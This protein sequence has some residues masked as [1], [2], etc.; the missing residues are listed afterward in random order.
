[1]AA[2]RYG[3]V[4]EMTILLARHGETDWNRENRFQGHA[5]VPL[6]DRGRE[7]A[8]ALADDLASEGITAVY[9]S[10]LSRAFETA[11]IAADRLGLPVRTD[12]RLMEVDVG[13]WSGLTRD[14]I[15]GRWPQAF[16]NWKAGVAGWDGESYD[17]LGVRTLAALLEIAARHPGE[18]V[19]AVAH[20][21]AVRVTLAHAEELDVPSHRRA[22]PAPTHNCAVHRLVARDGTLR[23]AG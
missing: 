23:R 22:F 6:N 9:S 12:P 20:G 8:R 5:D 16:E 7:Q 17:D 10:T 1:M 3:L 13:S 19:L 4:M 21:G 15:A 11:Q 2:G 14:E 18:T